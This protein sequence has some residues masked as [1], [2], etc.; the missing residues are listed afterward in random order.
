M[1]V[2]SL[3][4]LQVCTVIRHDIHVPTVIIIA[5]YFLDS[6]L[7]GLFLHLKSHIN[8]WCTRSAVEVVK[9]TVS[10]FKEVKCSFGRDSLAVQW[11]GS[12][13]G[14]GTRI[15]QTTWRSQKKKKKFFW[16]VCSNCKFP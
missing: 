16:Q 9:E 7:L 3:V 2:L 11:L 8:Y 15:L 5:S 1:C 6:I 4:S 13:P 12:I 10:S 14:R